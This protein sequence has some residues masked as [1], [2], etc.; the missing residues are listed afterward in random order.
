L[1]YYTLG[2]RKGLGIGGTSES[3]ERWFVVKKDLSENVLYVNNGECEEMFTKEVIA[4]D[5]NWV[6]L[7]RQRESACDFSREF[8]RALPPLPAKGIIC[9]AK[10]RYRQSDQKCEVEVLADGRV[11]AIFEKPQRAVTPGQWLVLYNGDEC[12]GGGQ[13]IPLCG[14]RVDAKADGVVL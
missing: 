7:P 13:I 4:G 9:T 12:L 6:T 10:T 2:Q 14:M 8:Q 5:F 1:M 11:K 3:T